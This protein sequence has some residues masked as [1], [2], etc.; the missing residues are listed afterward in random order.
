VLNIVGKACWQRA[1][2]GLVLARH[3][4]GVIAGLIPTED[5]ASVMI[6]T[7]GRLQRKL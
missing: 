5:M 7:D 1:A 3:A 4:L 2:T 6:A